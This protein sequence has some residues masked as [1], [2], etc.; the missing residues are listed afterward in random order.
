MFTRMIDCTIKPE[1][2]E[3]FFLT[4]QNE[5]LA[6]VKTQKGFKDL[7]C[8]GSDDYP[9]HVLVLTFWNTKSEAEDYYRKSAPM[10][11]LLKPYTRKATTEHYLVETSTIF[12]VAHGKAA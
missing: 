12:K 2:K 11:D 10:L 7:M 9:E 5:I 3:Q 8:L 4:V 6:F 1:A